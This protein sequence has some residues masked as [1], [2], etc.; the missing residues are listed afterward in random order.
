MRTSSR[1]N[2]ALL[3]LILSLF[4][5][6]AFAACPTGWTG[7]GSCGLAGTAAL[8]NTGTS[9]HTLP[10]LDGN[11]TYSGTS[12]FSKT[13][14]TP[15]SAAGGSGFIILPGTPPSSPVDGA[16]WTTTAGIYVQ[17]NGSTIGPLG[18]G[19]GTPANPSATASDTAVNGSASTYMRSD[20]APAVQKGSSSQFGLMEC[21]G[22]LLVCPG[23]ALTMG[24]TAVSPATYGDST[25]VAQVTIDQQGRVT[26]AANVGI[27]GG[28]SGCSVSGT[29]YQPL[30]VNSAG[31]GCD[32]DASASLNAG[33]LTLGASGTAGSV[34]MGNAT[35]GTAKI[36][37]PTG[38]LSTAIYT[39]P[40][41]G[42]RT[43]VAEDATETL[44]NKTIDGGSNT[45]SN[46]GNSSL[47]HS[48][49]ALGYG[50]TK[51]PGTAN[52][53]PA[54]LGDTIY[55]Q[56]IP[57]AYTGD[58]TIT[59]AE[60]N[61]VDFC[62][63]SSAIALSLPQA[64]TTGFE[65][66]A[67]ITI[68]NEN[69]GDCTISTTTSTFYGVPLSS[70]NIV[71]SQYAGVF[72][73]SDGTNWGAGG[74]TKAGITNAMLANASMTLA[75][76]SVSLGGTQAFSLG[77][78]TSGALASGSTAT[79]QSAG[80]NS[81]KVATTAYADAAVGAAKHTATIGWIATVNPNNAPIIIFPAN[82]TLTSLV[83]NVETAT[84]GTATVSV[85]LA[86]SGTACGSGTTVHSGSMDAN[87]TA[88]T[89]QTLTLTTTAVSAG[90]RLCLATTGTTSWTGGTG[91]GSV[92]V[93]YTT[94]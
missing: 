25:H 84:G 76:H 17:I 16:V 94:P 86:A 82:S 41:T 42:A 43:L 29:Q 5:A 61:G 35:S 19:G 77:D 58:H 70:S 38:A 40:P 20:A 14:T 53:T 62:N 74:I 36:Q 69:T 68:V 67:S 60:M 78:F 31:T 22:T 24:N 13:V 18:T 48:S 50:F 33:A 75:G 10:Y 4:G 91:I 21:D 92:T 30:V 63:K 88:A 37:P 12:A 72:L 32:A 39:L 9:G 85:K 28:G 65:K 6:S 73:V 83:G 93:G 90:N 59:A 11:N 7:L 15:A 80:D 54:S 44:T 71:L 1:I 66:G 2:A 64:G 27:S 47:S 26:A 3:A 56:A 8:A 79:T 34:T 87:G 51:T 23:G 52:A 55:P 45:L 49:V 57:N 46:I 81:T 89:N